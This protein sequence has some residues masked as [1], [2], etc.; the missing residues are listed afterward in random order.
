M[1]LRVFCSG[2]EYVVAESPEHANEL[3]IRDLHVTA[4][5]LPDRW[6]ELP[7]DYVLR[8]QDADDCDRYES[9]TCEVWCEIN[10]PGYLCEHSW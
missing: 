3:L 2:E 6:K 8:V 7:G 1:T 4:D 9:H 10:G 5:D